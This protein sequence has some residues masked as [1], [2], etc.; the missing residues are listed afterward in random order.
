[1]TP[2]TQDPLGRPT[3]VKQIALGVPATVKT[4]TAIQSAENAPVSALQSCTIVTLSA[5]PALSVDRD[6]SV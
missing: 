4:G 1:M 2:L 6:I 3:A 5:P